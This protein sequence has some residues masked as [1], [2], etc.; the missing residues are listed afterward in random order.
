[1]LAFL[2]L[3]KLKMPLSGMM[4]MESF[5]EIP[6]DIGISPYGTRQ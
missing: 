5:V 4:C 2:M 6:N 3:G 1:M